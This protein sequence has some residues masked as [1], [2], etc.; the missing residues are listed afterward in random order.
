M[1]YTDLV[2]MKLARCV[3]KRAIGLKVEDTGVS[4]LHPTKGWKRVS[5]ARIGIKPYEPKAA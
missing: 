1:K 4:Y 3:P 2:T 5:F